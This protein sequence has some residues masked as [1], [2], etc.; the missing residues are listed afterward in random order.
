M[1]DEDFE[2]VQIKSNQTVDI[3]EFVE[4]SEIEPV[5]FNEPYYLA[6]AKGGAKAY[7][8]LRNALERTGLVGLAKVVIRPPREHL[9]AIKPLDGILMLETLRF[10]DELRSPSDVPVPK[11][12]IGPKE[13]EMALSLVKAMASKWAPAKYHDEYREHLMEL[14][15]QK[16]KAGGKELPAPKRQGKQPAQGKIIDLVSLLQES[17]GQTQKAGKGRSAKTKQARAEHKKAA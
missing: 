12:E 1:K 16:V 6:P 7:A 8:L 11:V 15:E 9:A 13:L 4:L 10:Q 14:I 17:L 2:R 5:Y 3:R